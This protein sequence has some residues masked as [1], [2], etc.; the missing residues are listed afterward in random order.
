MPCRLRAS[1]GHCCWLGSK[2]PSGTGGVAVAS[3]AAAAE[4]VERPTARAALAAN[5]AAT[6][7][8]RTRPAL[9]SCGRLVDPRILA[10]SS[11]ADGSDHAVGTLGATAAG[12]GRLASAKRITGS[13]CCARRGAARGEQTDPL[14]QCLCRW[15][16]RGFRSRADS[17]RL[18]GRHG[19]FSPPRLGMALPKPRS[20]AALSPCW[21]SPSTR[22]DG[23]SVASHRAL[24]GSAG[25]AKTLP[26]FLYIMH[27]SCRAEPAISFDPFSASQTLPDP[28]GRAAF[29]EPAG[30]RGHG[31]V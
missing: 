13:S 18:D 29:T 6:A 1:G 17:S 5:A 26:P 16:R 19:G 8:K 22:L 30:S 12:G 15:R 4:A 21:L 27:I 23:R 24:G 10:L 9:P 28:F 11:S 14:R 31:A 7:S 2:P 3:S 20:E 25:P